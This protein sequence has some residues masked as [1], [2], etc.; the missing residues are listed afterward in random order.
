M[1]IHPY[2]YEQQIALKVATQNLYSMAQ[3][4]TPVNKVLFEYYQMN[5]TNYTLGAIFKNNNVNGSIF[6]DGL[7]NWLKSGKI[8]AETWGRPLQSAWCTQGQTVNN[9]KQIALTDEIKWTESQDHSKWMISEDKYSCF[10]DMNRMT[11]QWKRGGAF[12]CLE[13]STLNEALRKIIVSTD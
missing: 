11:S 3:G 9:V 10:G 5:P 6:E 1:M 4:N 7:I 12:Y 2:I 13:D 8:T